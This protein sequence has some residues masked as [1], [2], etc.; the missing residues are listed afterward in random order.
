MVRPMNYTLTAAA[1]LARVIHWA[2]HIE[3]DKTA[4]FQ[5]T[6]IVPVQCLHYF[7]IEYF[8]CDYYAVSYV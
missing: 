6:L 7:M 4:I 3:F 2:G 5:N 1:I 8:I